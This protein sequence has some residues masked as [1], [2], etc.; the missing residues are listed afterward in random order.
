MEGHHTLHL[1]DDHLKRPKNHTSVTMAL[2]PFI[3]IGV[4]QLGITHNL[5]KVY[6]VKA[7]LGVHTTEL[8]LE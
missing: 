5:L 1:S 4:H 3:I 8:Y 7:L 6:F 2:L